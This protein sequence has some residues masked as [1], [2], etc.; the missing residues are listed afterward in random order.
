MHR[1][2]TSGIDLRGRLQLPWWRRL[3]TPPWTVA[4]QLSELS[5]QEIRY[6][7]RRG[8]A[9]I[10]PTLCNALDSGAPVPLYVGSGRLPRHIVLAIGRS[11]ADGSGRIDCYEPASGHVLAVSLATLRAGR[12]PLG[13]WT[14]WWWAVL[15]NRVADGPRPVSRRPSATHEL[16]VASQLQPLVE[17]QPSQT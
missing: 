6:R 17:P 7:V 5:A 16:S 2:L 11:D 3:G 12:C 10:V 4:R 15:P 9:R 8:R 13:G 1:G 14:H